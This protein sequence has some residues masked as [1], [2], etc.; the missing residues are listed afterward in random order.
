[1][2]KETWWRRTGRARLLWLG[3]AAVI[4]VLFL[5]AVPFVAPLLGQR[6][7][8]LLRPAFALA[9]LGGLLLVAGDA[10]AALHKRYDRAND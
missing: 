8:G 1:M 6:A 10:L 7:A 9:L 5:F 3:V 2:R 4:V